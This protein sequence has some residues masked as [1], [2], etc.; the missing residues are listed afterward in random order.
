M[1][2]PRTAPLALALVPGQGKLVFQQCEFDT[3]AVPGVARR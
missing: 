3:L 1:Q 2:L